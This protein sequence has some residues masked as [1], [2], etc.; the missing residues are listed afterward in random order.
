MNA[1]LTHAR[2]DGSPSRLRRLSTH[3]Q[4]V[5]TMIAVWRTRRRERAEL[6]AM[7]TAELRDAGLTPYDA[8]CEGRKPFW[9]P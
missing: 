5:L 8:R 2:L 4:S 6:N 9:R 3:G 1:A 7:T